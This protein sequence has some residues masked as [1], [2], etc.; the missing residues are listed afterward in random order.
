[1][2]STRIRDSPFKKRLSTL[3]K[4]SRVKVRG[5]EMAILENPEFGVEFSP[6]DWVKFAEAC[7]SKGYMLLKNQMK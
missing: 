7:N 5:P 1:M 3:E 2:F 6:I 4:G